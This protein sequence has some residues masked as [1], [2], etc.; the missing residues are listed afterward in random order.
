MSAKGPH[1]TAIASLHGKKDAILKDFEDVLKNHGIEDASISRIGLYIKSGP[2]PLCPD[3]SP[4]EF[5]CVTMPN[6]EI[7]CNWVCD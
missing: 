3:G 7:V 1:G 4:P 5:R 2:A 6:G